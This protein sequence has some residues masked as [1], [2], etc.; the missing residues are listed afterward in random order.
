MKGP[1][2]LERFQPHSGRFRRRAVQVSIPHRFTIEREF[3]SAVF[4]TLRQPELEPG[5]AEV[6]LRALMRV[7]THDA[8]A[9]AP[10]KAGATIVAALRDTASR[11]RL[12]CQPCLD[13][14]R[15]R[16]GNRKSAHFE[17]RVRLE[18]QSEGPA[19][20]IGG[21]RVY[22][23]PVEPDDQAASTTRDLNYEL[24]CG[25]DAAG[26]KLRTRGSRRSQRCARSRTSTQGNAGECV[27]L[28]PAC[29]QPCQWRLAAHG[30]PMQAACRRRGL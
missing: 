20:R 18:Q 27:Q 26:G 23:I 9:Y 2:Q 14:R 24:L 15:W 5:A 8:G 19:V 3:H 29:R 1:S 6:P 28:R 16:A 11:D 7:S 30:N 10:L 21:S 12:G 17:L 22:L 4:R 13:R 25:M